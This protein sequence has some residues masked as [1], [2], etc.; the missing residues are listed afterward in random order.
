MVSIEGKDWNDVVIKDADGNKIRGIVSFNIYMN[1]ESAAPKID[2]ELYI[3]KI[4][5]NGEVNFIMRDPVTGEMKNIDSVSFENGD[6][7]VA[8]R[9]KSLKENMYKKE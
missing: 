3:R 4:K 7:F 1:Y 2:L 9:F 5:I 8:N 6:E